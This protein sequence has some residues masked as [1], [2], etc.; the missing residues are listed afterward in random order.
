MEELGYSELPPAPPPTSISQLLEQTRLELVQRERTEGK[1]FSVLDGEW[2]DPATFADE[3][4]RFLPADMLRTSKRSPRSLPSIQKRS[5]GGFV[6]PRDEAIKTA[7]ADVQHILADVENRQRAA[8]GMRRRKLKETENVALA[9]VS[10]NGVELRTRSKEEKL[11]FSPQRQ[12]QEGQRIAENEKELDKFGIGTQEDEEAQEGSGAQDRVDAEQKAEEAAEA[13]VEAKQRLVDKIQRVE[14]KMRAD[15]IRRD[16][17]SKTKMEE[18]AKLEKERVVEERE[19]ASVLLAVT[20]IQTRS[21]MLRARRK[22]EARKEE[23]A[24]SIQ[25]KDF[26]VKYQEKQKREREQLLTAEHALQAKMKATESNTRSAT[27][28]GAREI[29]EEVENDD[30][31]PYAASQEDAAEQGD[32]PAPAGTVRSLCAMLNPVSPVKSM[33]ELQKEALNEEARVQAGGVAHI[34]SSSFFDDEDPHHADLSV[35][36]GGAETSNGDIHRSAIFSGGS[37]DPDAVF[38]SGLPEWE[39]HELKKLNSLMDS[40]EDY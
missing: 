4:E 29:S 21:R 35:L 10:K 3:R 20:K 27:T 15:R 25:R 5:K 26:L 18:D 40:D 31:S 13:K 22:C 7:Q 12:Q 28:R 6:P 38:S 11:S 23:I 9:S 14:Q 33:D 37:A 16:E 39:R 8:A 30:T 24:A 2:K 19:W 32:R 34:H 36:A 17:E 1:V